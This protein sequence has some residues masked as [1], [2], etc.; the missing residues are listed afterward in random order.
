MADFYCGTG[1]QDIAKALSFL[2]ILSGKSWEQA[3]TRHSPKMC[4]II[5]S[6]VN[7]V[8]R[9]SLEEEIKIT[10]REKLVENKYTN[11]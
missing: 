4:D 1:G 5:S 10:I 9:K 7:K 2:G 8:I 11:E 3:L 6:V